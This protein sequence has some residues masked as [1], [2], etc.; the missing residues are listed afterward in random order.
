MTFE[1]AKKRAE[2]LR[3]LINEARYSYHVLGKDIYQPEVLDSLKKELYD[4]EQK[5]P[6]LITPDSP[7]QR[8]GGEPLKEF[9][10]SR[11]RL[12][13]LSFD[14][15]F[16]FED[17]KNWQERNGK[18]IPA[19]TKLDYFCE[20][21]IDGLAIKLVYRNGI[22]EVGATRGDGYLG[23]D[24]TQNVKTIE[25]IPLSLLPLEKILKNLK[26]ISP[27]K[28]FFERVS[29]HFI[30]GYPEEI[31]VRGEVFMHTEDFNR[32]NEERQKM[33]ETLF[34]N[35]RNAASGSLR[36]LDPKITAQRK[37][38][39]FAY[40][41]ITD[42][43]Q[44]TH[45]EEHLILKCLGF[46][47]NPNNKLCR[48]LDEIFE[49]RN[50]WEKKRNELSY[51]IDGIVVIVNDNDIFRQLG[52][53]GKAPRGAIAFKFS[54]K[55][56]TTT[57]EEVIFQTGRTGIITPVAIL[58]PV[59]IG[60]VIVSKASLH[61]EDE[62]DR[63]DVRIGDTVI[64]A[65]AGDVIPQVQEVIKELRTGREKKITFPEKCPNCQTPIIKEGA[66]YRC[67]NKK[68]FALQKEKII[69][70]VSKGAFDIVGLGEKI[71]EKLI[72]SGLIS[73]PSDLFSLKIGELR[74]LP[75]FDV[76]LERKIIENIQSKKTISLSKFLYSLGILHIG[77]QNAKIL[78]NFLQKKRKIEKPFDLISI[79]NQIKAEELISIHSFGQKVVGSIIEWFKDEENM[80]L[81]EKLTLAGIR[82]MEE[83]KG[84]QPLSGQVFAF[85]GELEKYSRNEA[86]EIVEKLGGQTTETISKRVNFLVVGK[87]P[88]SKL[89]KAK[90]LSIITITESEFEEMIKTIF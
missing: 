57:L 77:E 61:N 8:I 52:V 4:L 81:L 90:K 42:L 30:K 70:F 5:F 41:L 45:E 59:L 66:H 43:G 32:L 65:R 26:E 39:S 47:T 62:I 58:K 17:L 35:P 21:K 72:D 13:M 73:D 1:E 6:Q 40:G 55:Q 79:F 67:P 23:E 14:D 84:S 31:E 76:I 89:E 75:G 12:P 29:K 27:N 44:K 19:G 48:N 10:K 20:L 85:T 16:S 28:N 33:G 25:A 22:L 34:A 11:H 78:A 15:A 24:V 38:D 2:K 63:L 36:Q 68:C 60:G 9:P 64:I 3:E 18:L 49:F 80:K 53:V 37:L 88:G 7:T 86:K 54:P 50:L 46:K 87:N 69:H 74:N 82:I 83:K 51:E 71:I 56:A